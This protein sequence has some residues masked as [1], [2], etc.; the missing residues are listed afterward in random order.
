[1]YKVPLIPQF[2]DLNT[3]SETLFVNMNGDNI[4]NTYS[5][6]SKLDN[7]VVYVYSRFFLFV[8]L[9]LFIYFVLNLFTTLIIVL[10]FMEEKCFC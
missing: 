1:M 9:A 8:F 5:G 7:L 4:Q 3:A 10:I 2:S 6:I